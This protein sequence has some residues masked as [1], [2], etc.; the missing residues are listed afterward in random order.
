MRG[1]LTGNGEYFVKTR[2]NF[3]HPKFYKIY[4]IPANFNKIKNYRCE[5]QENF[6]F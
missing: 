2:A 4:Q 3:F 5:D 1:R 6:N